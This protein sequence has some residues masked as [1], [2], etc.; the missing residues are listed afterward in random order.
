MRESTN[1]L[2]VAGINHIAGAVSTIRAAEL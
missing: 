2:A 1:F